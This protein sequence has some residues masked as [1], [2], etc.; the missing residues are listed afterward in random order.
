MRQRR[1]EEARAAAREHR[2]HRT[3]SR[4][5]LG[6]KQRIH[7]G[8]KQYIEAGTRLPARERLPVEL[9]LPQ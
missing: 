1:G 3:K 7:E 8:E 2:P 9:Q 5:E 6:A 4:D